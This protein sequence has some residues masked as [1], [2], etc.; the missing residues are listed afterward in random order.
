MIVRIGNNAITAKRGFSMDFEL[1]RLSN[2]LIFV[3]WG[4][5]PDSTSVNVYLQT[6]EK[7][8]NTANR[9]L[10]FISDLGGGDI[11]DSRALRRLAELTWH[12]H[13]GGSVAYG[14]GMN[15]RAYVDV[16]RH[17]AA[18]AHHSDLM[19]SVE[20]A[21]DYLESLKPGVTATVDREVME[22]LYGYAS[23]GG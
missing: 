2:E 5:H 17:L 4:Q 9:K 3:R 19:W 8:L 15:A 6:L 20:Q 11:S 16:V 12:H 21:L 1:Y 14:Q 10:Y 22:L 7:L 18:P 23:V 13:W